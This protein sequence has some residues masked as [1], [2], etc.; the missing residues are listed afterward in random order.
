MINKKTQNSW[1]VGNVL[2]SSGSVIPIFKD[3]IKKEDQSQLLIQ[4]WKNVMSIPEA[5]QLILQ[6]G[7]LAEE[8][9]FVLD[10][11]ET[12]K[13]IDLAMDL[14]KLSGFKPNQIPIEITGS[15]PGE[16]KVE[17]LSLPS[18]SLDR[19]KHDE[20]F[21]LN[22]KDVV[23]DT[24]KIL[25]QIQSLKTKLNNFNP[26]EVEIILSSILNDYSPMTIKNTEGDRFIVA[27]DNKAKL[28]PYIIFL[29]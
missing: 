19:T 25:E 16:K 2:G 12:V 22:S 15:R 9:I 1:L 26:N 5:S 27:E 28:N 7:S 11:G 17:E 3:Q 13:I 20:I 24:E 6:A 4:M 10:M 14:I 23:N 21:V 18:E 8:E 29:V